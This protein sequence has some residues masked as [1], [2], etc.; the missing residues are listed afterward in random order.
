L[1]SAAGAVAAAKVKMKNATR[2]KVVAKYMVLFLGESCDRHA[3]RLM[4]LAENRLDP[5]D[6]KRDRS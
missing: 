4:V 3:I 6:E 1:T 2:P 5:S